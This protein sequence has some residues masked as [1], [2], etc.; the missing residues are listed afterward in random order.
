MSNFFKNIILI[1]I[2]IIITLFM[3]EI[4]LNL[5]DYKSN[6][7]KRNLEL[8]KLTESK[9][10]EFLTK[11]EFF[12]KYK[13]KNPLAVV[14]INSLMY[15]LNSFEDF[16]PLTSI[17]NKE[18]IHCNENGYFS[19]YNADRYGLNN[20]NPVWNESEIDYLLVGDSFVHGAC[21]NYRDT[22]T[23][24]LKLLT[25]KKI[26]NVGVSSSGPLFQFAILKEFLKKK[27]TS[28][29]IWFF[30]E[31]ND[32]KNLVTESKSQILISYLI[33]QNFYQNIFENQSLTD[34]IFLSKLKY[35]EQNRKESNF[36]KKNK[37]KK[38]LTLHNLV[39]IK[40]EYRKSIKLHK[41]DEIEFN[42]EYRDLLYKIFEEIKNLSK[43]YNFEFS[44][45]YLPN[46]QRFKKTKK[47]N[48]EFETISKI[49]ELN[50]FKLID[51]AD[52]ITKNKIPINEIYP[53]LNRDDLHFNEKG[54]FFITKKV[55]Q[56]LN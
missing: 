43:K 26:I 51:L 28:K 30:Y 41:R 2:S 6:K 13:N 21:V 32:L 3:I 20:Y 46:I 29:V 7:E 35:E 49:V 37:L 54:Y 45:V 24:N 8:Q 4:Y 33:N 10:K 42:K 17:S 16:L 18:T 12:E 19:I 1:L 5:I 52:E 25:N 36:E 47:F 39:R 31:G 27:K 14:S 44:I 56:Y 11:Y 38:I 50:N 53:P 22:I 48:R 15:D 40:N 23:E 55:Y 9:G 34:K